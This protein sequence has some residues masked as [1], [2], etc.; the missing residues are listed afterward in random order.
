MMSPRANTGDTERGSGLGE[1][2]MNLVLDILKFSA[3]QEP[4]YMSTSMNTFLATNNKNPYS[5][6]L[7]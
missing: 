3:S 4:I 5:K 7:K 2:L 1:A 6:W